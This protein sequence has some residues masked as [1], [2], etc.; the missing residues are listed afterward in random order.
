MVLFKLESTFTVLNRFWSKW[1][2]WVE[3]GE[4]GDRRRERE[5]RH[6]N[7][8]P[9]KKLRLRLG[10]STGGVWVEVR[11]GWG[12]ANANLMNSFK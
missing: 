10:W 12:S 5:T 7:S 9:T 6:N 11:L 2:T 4:T 3:T 8:P 1:P